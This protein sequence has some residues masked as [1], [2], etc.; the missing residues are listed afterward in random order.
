MKHKQKKQ[1]WN[2]EVVESMAAIHDFHWEA[3]QPYQLRI[4]LNDKK[5]DYFPQTGRS[6]WVGSNTWFV[7]ND[8]EQFIMKEL[9]IDAKVIK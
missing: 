1:A 7:I 3:V 2:T 4:T 9:G 5:L 6:T 8:I